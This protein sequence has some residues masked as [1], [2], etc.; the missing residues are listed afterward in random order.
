MPKFS[1]FEKNTWQEI[2][3]E[4]HVIKEMKLDLILLLK[5]LII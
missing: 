5:K 4:A 1:P 3:N 2:K